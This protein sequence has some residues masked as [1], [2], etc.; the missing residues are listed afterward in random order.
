MIRISWVVWILCSLCYLRYRWCISVIVIRGVAGI[1]V[2]AGDAVVLSNPS[3]SPVFSRC[4]VEEV[5]YRQLSQYGLKLCII[6]DA[7]IVQILEFSADCVQR[8][9]R[10]CFVSHFG[11]MKHNLCDTIAMSCGDDK[12]I[13]CMENGVAIRDEEVSMT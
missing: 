10:G 3:I 13:D 6:H 7:R 2:L 1:N 5:H 8:A 4:R 11:N 12:R 9:V